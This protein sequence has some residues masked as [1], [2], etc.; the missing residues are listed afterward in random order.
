[1]LNECDFVVLLPLARADPLL[2]S[3]I[4]ELLIA[5]YSKFCIFFL[6]SADFFSKSTIF[7][8]ILS[9]MPSECQTVLTPIRP[10]VLSGLIWVHPNCLQRLSTDDTSRHRIIIARSLFFSY[11]RQR[12]TEKMGSY[13]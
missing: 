10:D 7:E 6:S 2:R 11:F 13:Q 4:D 1:M 9:G 12:Y 3:R 5:Y 8:K